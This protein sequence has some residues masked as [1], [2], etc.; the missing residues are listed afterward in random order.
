[1]KEESIEK[2]KIFVLRVQ[3]EQGQLV[4]GYMTGGNRPLMGSSNS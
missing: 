1:M 4:K 2:N 3:E